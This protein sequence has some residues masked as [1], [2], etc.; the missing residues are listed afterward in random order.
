MILSFSLCA[1]L[2][3]IGPPLPPL[4]FFSFTL[5][6]SFLFSTPADNRRRLY[7]S[8]GH[9]VVSRSSGPFFS[10]LSL[11]LPSL[12]H[13][14]FFYLVPVF[15]LARL[16]GTYVCMAACT[17]AF[18]WNSWDEHQ[19]RRLITLLSGTRAVR[20]RTPVFTRA[21]GTRTHESSVAHINLINPTDTSG[22]TCS[23]APSTIMRTR[24]RPAFR[25]HFRWLGLHRGWRNYARGMMT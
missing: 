8:A 20:V 7:L 9:V 15:I 13:L 19:E 21:R 25:R 14:S 24:V 1:R 17:P 4:P 16:T 2:N 22:P 11:F 5:F 6:R 18:M 23:V 12:L 10:S 3:L